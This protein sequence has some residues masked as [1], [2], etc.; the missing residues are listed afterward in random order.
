METHLW[1]RWNPE[2]LPFD[3]K[4]SMAEP[5]KEE[6]KK[7]QAKANTFMYRSYETHAVPNNNRKRID[8]FNVLKFS[9]P[10]VNIV[11][12]AIKNK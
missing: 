5:S 2:K 8:L 11:L 10:R 3:Q 6:E 7:R 9:P 4:R 1:S 12:L